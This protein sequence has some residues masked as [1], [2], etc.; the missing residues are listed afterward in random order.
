MKE[1]VFSKKIYLVSHFLIHS[2]MGG[3]KI[4][5]YISFNFWDFQVNEFERLSNTEK[6]RDVPHFLFF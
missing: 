4:L 1:K 2:T 6:N 3:Q 5:S